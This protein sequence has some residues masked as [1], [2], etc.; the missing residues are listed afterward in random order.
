MNREEAY[1]YVL[2]KI[3]EYEDFEPLNVD[4]LI[5]ELKE[6]FGLFKELAFVIIA[7]AWYCSVIKVRLVNIPHFSSTNESPRKEKG[8]QIRYR[9]CGKKNCKCNSGRQEDL[10]GPYKYRVTWD[11]KLK[12]R[13]WEYLGPTKIT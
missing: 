10:H 7:R 4:H 2:K 5:T 6:E 3:E 13:I 9:K 8:I 1:N 11:P 12:K